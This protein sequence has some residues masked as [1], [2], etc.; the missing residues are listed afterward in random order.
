MRKEMRRKERQMSEK[1]A[2]KALEKAEWGT[3]CVNGDDGYPYGVPV[4]Y[5]FKDGKIIFHSATAGYKFDAV[6]RDEKVSFTVVT[7]EKI[8]P[9]KFAADYESIIVFGKARFA[10]DREQKEKGL[11]ELVK[12][13][14]SRYMKEGQEY[15][16]KAFNE[17]CVIEIIPEHIS[18]KR[19][20]VL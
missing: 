12:V 17:A 4:N 2:L 20:V 7:Y 3:F 16:Q 18:G 9:E 10:E 6:K 15:I 5:V 8:V 1:D 13:H 19:C 11:L 14:H